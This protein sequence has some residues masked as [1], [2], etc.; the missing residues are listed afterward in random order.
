MVEGETEIGDCPLDDV[1][2]IDLRPELLGVELEPMLAIETTR[3]VAVES[4]VP[5]RDVSVHDISSIPKP[6][7]IRSEGEI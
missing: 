6:T 3:G 2:D 4:G 5:L 1:N 7:S